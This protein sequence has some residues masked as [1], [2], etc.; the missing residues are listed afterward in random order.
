MNDKLELLS[1]SLEIVAFFCVT[2][3]LY[4]EV[5]LEA[6]TKRG[7]EIA[8]DLHDLVLSGVRAWGQTPKNQS[9]KNDVGLLFSLT[10]VLDVGLWMI[11]FLDGDPSLRIFLIVL[12][13]PLG[14]AINGGALIYILAKF[15]NWLLHQTTIPGLLLVIGA[16]LFVGAKGILW[17]PLFIKLISGTS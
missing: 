10:L 16:V 5:R 4:G 11:V 8:R 1:V 2:I 15:A 6:A 7:S 17:V 14:V 12:W 3:E 13:L 9:L